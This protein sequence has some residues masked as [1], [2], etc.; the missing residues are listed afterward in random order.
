MKSLSDLQKELSELTTQIVSTIFKYNTNHDSQSGRFSR[1]TTSGWSPTELD[2]YAINK[3]T[4]SASTTSSI[5]TRFLSGMAN[6]YNLDFNKEGKNLLTEYNTAMKNSR[7]TGWTGDMKVEKLT[8][9]G[10][11]LETRAGW[12]LGGSNYYKLQ[13]LIDPDYGV[14]CRESWAYD[15]ATVVSGGTPYNSCG[16]APTEEQAINAGILH[17]AAYMI[18]TDRAMK[19]GKATWQDPEN[20]MLG[21]HSWANTCKEAAAQGWKPPS[22]YSKTSFGELFA[23]CYVKAVYTGTTGNKNV[24]AELEMVILR[25]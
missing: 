14:K 15:R 18:Q 6:I 24:D 17:E 8:V 22:E 4:T 19:S 21:T 7:V 20:P 9:E 16:Y 13:L 25:G 12:D 1:S 11:L 10:R 23:E 3:P 5:S 2:P